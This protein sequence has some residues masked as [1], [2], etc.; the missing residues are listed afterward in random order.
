MK[1]SIKVRQTKK[2][3]L[4][5]TNFNHLPFGQTF[6]D[7]MFLAEY[8]NGKWQNFQIVPFGYLKLHPANLAIHYG[9]SIF[10]GLKASVLH[11]GT[12][13]LFR[14]D[15]NIERMNLSALRMA[16]PPFPADVFMDAMEQLI[17]LDKQWIPKTEG[18]SLYVRPVMFA[19]DEFL[20][21]RP[22]KKFQF[23][24]MTG[25]TGPYYSA[26]VRLKVEETY[27]RAVAGGIGEAK[28]AGNYAASLLP[29]KLAVE[30]GYDQ[31]MWMDGAN[32]KYIQEV[33]TMNLFFVVN[34]KAWTPATD[35]AILKGITRDSFLQI[36][37]ERNIPVEERPITI[38][39]IVEAYHAGT[40]QEAFGAG[41]AAVV[42]PISEITY[43]DL[44]MKLPLVDN[45]PV[46]QLLKNEITG[47]RDGTIKDTRGWIRPIP[48]FHLENATVKAS[49]KR[50]ESLAY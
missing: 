20:G 48:A 47:L 17:D 22:G 16:M 30:A 12:P 31:I 24:I 41:T 40:L 2:S 21:V 7:H 11:D 29:A 19:T 15:K 37:R 13:A 18:S 42:S 33:G 1:Y 34:G 36:L 49:K 35:G 44:T 50:A 28:T 8:D 6:S 39:E 32:K 38:D 9:Q 3:K 5:A 4:A 45:G 23:I 26:P 46:G 43:R 27:V 14:A 25:P 10:E